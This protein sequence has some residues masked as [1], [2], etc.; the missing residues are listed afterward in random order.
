MVSAH[1]DEMTQPIGNVALARCYLLRYVFGFSDNSC[2]DVQRSSWNTQSLVV[3]VVAVV[4][5]GKD[6]IVWY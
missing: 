2:L 3:A 6:S 4:V 1:H 5:Y